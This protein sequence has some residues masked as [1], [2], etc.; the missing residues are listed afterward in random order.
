MKKVLIA[1]T[2]N[3]KFEAVSKVLNNTIFPENEFILE[4]LAS[5]EL[6]IKDEKE[7]GTNL[8]RARTKAM[9]AFN[10]LKETNYNY[11]FVVGLD[12][13]IRVKGILEENIKEYIDKIL[14]GNYIDEGEEYAF[15]R[16]Y[17]II[18]KNMK[19][20]Q[21]TIDIPYVYHKANEKVE[22]KAHTYPLSKVA[23]PIGS[24]KPICDFNEKE[25]IDYYLKY[26]KNDLMSLNISK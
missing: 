6:N 9:N 24:D 20:Y 17:V 1:T 16:A 4:S 8:E 11:D 26:V 23:Y 5:I 18:D 14:N 21:T 13:A 25:E 19:I 12:D 10:A 2:N 22:L 3:D 7:V 15:N